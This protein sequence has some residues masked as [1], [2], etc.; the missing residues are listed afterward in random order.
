MTES[1]TDL[2]RKDRAYTWDDKCAEAFKKIKGL[3]VSAPVLV[4]PQFDNP[5]ILT[6][7]ASDVGVGAAL[8]QKD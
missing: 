5:F 6:V 1:L 4:T 8:V 7:D 2:L 3:L